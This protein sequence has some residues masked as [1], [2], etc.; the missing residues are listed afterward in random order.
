[1]V[2]IL[3]MIVIYLSNLDYLLFYIP[4]FSIFIPF[5]VLGFV[6]YKNGF[7]LALYFIL[8]WGIFTAAVLTAFVIKHIHPDLVI[9]EYIIVIGSLLE[10][11]ILSFALSKKT[12]TLLEEKNQQEKILVHQSRLA[13]MGEML[14]NISHQW[15]Q[16][17]NRIASFIMNMQLHIYEHYKNETY[18]LEKLEESQ[19]QLE[20]MSHT[21]DDFSDF[22]KKDRKKE[23][24]AVSAPINNAIKIISSSLHSNNITLD[25]H[26]KEDFNLTS[27]PKELAQVILNLLQNSKDQIIIRNIKEGSI[28][29]MVGHNF[30]SIE[31]NAGGIQS[32]IINRICEPY[33]TTKEKHKGTGL[34]LYMSTIILENHFQAQLNI[35]NTKKGAKFSIVFG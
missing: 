21:I 32:D 9:N 27:Y 4:Q 2:Y 20:Y 26:M 30:I 33:F 17:L 35:E 3:F 5:I 29:L 22:Y 13:S 25:L 7:T 12:K 23:N 19:M 10:A 6:L 31:D 18:L 1:M 14:A 28:I 8:G 15:R 24:F 34:G 11:I 16:P